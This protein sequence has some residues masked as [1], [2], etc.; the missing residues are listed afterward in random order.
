V[1]SMCRPAALALLS[2]LLAAA[3]ASGQK[4][5]PKLGP[6]LDR[7]RE[8]VA[9]LRYEDAQKTLDKVLRSGTNSPGEMTEIYLLLGEVYASLGEDEGASDAFLRA[10]AIDPAIDLRAGL[11]PKIKDPFGK[12]R[13]SQRGKKPLTIAHR[14][15]SAN[16]PT[17]AV[18]V[19]ADPFEMIVGAKLIYKN[20]SGSDRSVAGVGK[21]R[22]DLEL[23]DGVDRF[24]VAAI[25]E[26]GNRLAELGSEASP[27]SLDV[28]SGGARPQGG[29]DGEKDDERDG[30]SA[31]VASESDDGPRKPF[32][33]H[34]AVWGGVAVGFAGIG[35]L[36][37]LST[38]SAISELDDIRNNSQDYEFSEAQAVA[39]K[40][41][42]RA[43]YTNLSFAVAGACAVVSG[44]L[45]FR[46]GSGKGKEER[47][48]LVPVVGQ[49]G[50]GV[51]AHLRF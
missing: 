19:Q 49:D 10:L 14:I 20:D 35:L 8:E 48:A 28:D 30:A 26:H 11:S 9:E 46:R 1:V 36:T 31:A 51:A 41:E 7:A 37:G 50:A 17:I 45:F 23:P 47:A 44:V 40:A 38:R 42:R 43:L 3:P 15:L 4:K 13:K 18:L 39:D 34:W 27:L 29:G 6:G 32:Y 24:V 16:P 5:K 21:E 12:A 33:A 22:I 25:D 2:L